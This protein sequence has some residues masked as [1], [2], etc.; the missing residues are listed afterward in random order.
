MTISQSCTLTCIGLGKKWV[1]VR[2]IVDCDISRVVKAVE[3]PELE[4]NARI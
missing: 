2:G 3:R 1:G 4:L